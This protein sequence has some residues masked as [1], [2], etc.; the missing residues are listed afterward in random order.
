LKPLVYISGPI[1]LGNTIV[2]VRNGCL[3]WETL[4]AGGLCTPIAPHWSIQQEM[5]WPITH[6]EWIEYDLELVARCDAVLR[7][8]GESKGA[9]QECLFA[10]QLG[11][12]VF[13]DLNELARGLSTSPSIC[14]RHGG[15]SAT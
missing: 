4:R 2:N 11:L 15:P 3:A 12:P 6:A 7:L 5:V 9:D 1:S 14:R 10:Q 13:H 8:P